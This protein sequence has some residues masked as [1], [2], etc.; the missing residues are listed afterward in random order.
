MSS[1]DPL[2]PASWPR[3][4]TSLGIALDRAFAGLTLV[5]AAGIVGILIAIVVVLGTQ[6]WP[7]IQQFGWDFL[8]AQTWNPVQGKEAYGILP[9]I[10]GTLMSSGIALVLAV[11]LGLG[12]AIFLSE[13]YLPAGIRTVTAISRDALASLP[14]DLR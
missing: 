11:P 10:Y 12:T 9:M 7:A 3:A 4:R 5:V 2:T 13:D 1:S 6:A 8:V 14:E